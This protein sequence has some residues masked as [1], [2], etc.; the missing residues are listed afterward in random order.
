MLC[1][2]NSKYVTALC[3]FVYIPMYFVAPVCF[4]TSYCDGESLSDY[5]LSFEQ[6]C[7]GL[8][9]VSFASSG[10]CLL[11]PVTGTCFCILCMYKVNN[12]WMTWKLEFTVCYIFVLSF[13]KSQYKLVNPVHIHMH[14]CIITI[15][16]IVSV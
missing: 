1:N 12:V 14:I 6:C 8:S 10:Q 4:N 11:C 16:F 3:N 13:Y 9:G 5:L 15:M 7:S 2:V